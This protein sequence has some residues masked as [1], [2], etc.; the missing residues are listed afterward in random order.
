MKTEEKL[1]SKIFNTEMEF[2]LTVDYSKSLD[3][4]I[5][6][7]HYEYGDNS[8]NSTNFPVIK[9]FGQTDDI[10]R[11][12][13]SI[14]KSEEQ[15]GTYHCFDRV[16]QSIYK[17]GNRLANLAEL[18][19]FG[20]SHPLFQYQEQILCIGSLWYRNRIFGADSIAVSL[21]VCGVDRILNIHKVNG[22]FFYDHRH[23]ILVV[24]E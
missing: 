23:Y 18:L 3:E 15:F 19:T 24:V 14:I 11:V 12:I 7:G 13:A 16:I 21:G 22:D 10:V 4:M 5:K 1:K 9:P 17:K 20:K 2:D 8:I 6:D